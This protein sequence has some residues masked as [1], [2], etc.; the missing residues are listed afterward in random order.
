MFAEIGTPNTEGS[1][2]Q[3]LAGFL[4]SILFFVFSFPKM[5]VS[6][7]RK[8]KFFTKHTTFLVSGPLSKDG[9][10]EQCTG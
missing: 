2:N 7:S 10:M 9:R 3:T 1:D 8:N 4:F 5:S 6:Y